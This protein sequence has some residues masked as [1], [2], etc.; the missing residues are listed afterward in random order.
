MSALRKLAVATVA[1]AMPACAAEGEGEAAADEGAQPAFGVVQV[2][3]VATDGA[4]RSSV[5]AKFMRVAPGERALAERVVGGK[6][7]VPAAGECES[8]AALESAAVF[9]D[10]GPV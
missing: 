5:S 9:D 1:L 2:E 10:G 4:T 8:L 3:L 6:P 7:L